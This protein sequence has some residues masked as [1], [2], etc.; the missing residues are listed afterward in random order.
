[1]HGVVG[2]VGHVGLRGYRHIGDGRE[3]RGEDADACCPPRNAVTAFEEVL[4]ARLTSH[5]IVAQQEHCDEVDHE[6]QIVEPAEMSG[7]GDGEFGDVGRADSRFLL[8]INNIIGVRL[9]AF[10]HCC[11]RTR[12]PLVAKGIRPRIRD[13]VVDEERVAEVIPLGRMRE[14]VGLRLLKGRLED[15]LVHAAE[16]QDVVSSAGQGGSSDGGKVGGR[17]G[18]T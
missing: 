4:R 12:Q 17:G 11:S 3:H 14:V 10:H 5:K 1:M 13:G 9:T 18:S 7:V 15:F 6:H 16:E 2:P 8:A